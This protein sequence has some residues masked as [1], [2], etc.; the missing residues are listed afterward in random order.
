MKIAGVWSGHDCSFCVLDNGIPTIHA[1]LERY[2]REKSPPGDAIQF[3][4]Q[5]VEEPEKITHFAS[6]FPKKKL[7]ANEKSYERAKR[8]VEKNEGEI[9]FISH[10]MAHAA[11]AFYSSNLKNAVVLTIDG[12]G[13]EDEDGGE[14]ACSVYLGEDKNLSLVRT[15]LPTEINIGG[16][17]TRVTRYVF[18]LNN[19]WPMGGQ[20][21][22][23]MA[24]AALG[25][26][27]KYFE[28]FRTMLTRDILLAGFKPPNQ[29]VGAVSPNDPVH[30][31]LDHWVKLADS[32]DQEKYDLAAGL[33]SAT[34]WVLREILA[35]VLRD[36]GAKNLCIAGGVSLNSVAMGKILEWFPQVENIHIPPVPYDGGLCLGASQWLWH[37][38]LQN[39]RIVWNKNFS[40]YLGE[41][42]S[43]N[44]VTSSLEEAV[45]TKKIKCDTAEIDDIIEL[46]EDGKIVS[47][48]NG[49]SESGRRALGNRSILADP[50]NPNMKDHV[51]KK[52]KHRQWYRPFAPSILQSEVKNWFTKDVESPYMQFVLRFIPSMGERVP[53]VNHFDGTA[54]LQTVREEDNLWYF[55]FLTKWQ[56]KTGVPII[57]NTSFNDREPICE[58]P[59][60]ALKCY[61]GT[62]IDY[63]YFVEQKILVSKN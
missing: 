29:P 45:L 23:V 2:N 44:H 62:D 46:L 63:L 5:R 59:E 58:T 26:P 52:V 60:H 17:W 1:E 61:L 25:D 35:S 37:H 24:M 8:I 48:F 56:Q 10:H 14:S 34:E 21:G 28:D 41:K 9:H 16:V 32:S 47:V 22:S 7:T 38:K 43:D 18:R 53:A 27:E 19:G 4:F 33:Q 42:W 36:T 15:F 13:V 39:D 20:E 55:N 40:P 6:I 11:H 50:R 31:Y 12:G 57:L 3:L 51:N 30:P 49:S 54:R